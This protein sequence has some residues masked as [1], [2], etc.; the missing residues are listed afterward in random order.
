MSMG[1][2]MQPPTPTPVQADPAEVY[3]ELFVPAL[4]APA[5]R[6]V[7]DVADP[8]AG[9]KLLDVGCGTGALAGALV[10]RVG[11]GGSVVG[12]DPNPQMLAVARRKPWPVRWVDGRAEALPFGDATFDAVV[13]QFA[14]MFFDDRARALR[15]M[16]RVLQQRGTLCVAVCDAVETSPGYGRLAGLLQRLFGREVADAFRAPFA[17]GDRQRLLELCVGSGWPEA[18]VVSRPVEVGFGSVDDMVAADRACIW[19]LGG[20][21]DA[22]QF[23]RLRA[24]A[25]REL[26]P[27]VRG[28]GRVS[29]AMPVLIARAVA[30]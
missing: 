13:S 14:M 19:T 24:E 17:L 1:A 2:K 26:Q 6:V 3:D 4:F 25:R 27:F 29:F 22:A 16:R 9:S 23:D 15:E 8:P 11:A 7:A 18:E 28:D 12:V 20:L 21:L 30:P 10:E 5:A